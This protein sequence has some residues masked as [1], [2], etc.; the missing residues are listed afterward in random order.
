MR[1]PNRARLT[2]DAAL[3][4]FCSA[5]DY[6]F[7]TNG[8]TPAERSCRSFLPRMSA[9]DL[10][11]QWRQ[12][13]HAPTAGSR[14]PACSDSGRVERR[15]E[16][17]RHHSFGCRAARSAIAGRHASKISSGGRLLLRRLE[18]EV[19]CASSSRFVAVDGRPKRYDVLWT[20]PGTPFCPKAALPWARENRPEIAACS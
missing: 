13:S 18:P 8:I 4:L 15:P 6:W 3:L 5:S 12:R 17:P 7:A 14:G 20:R 1:K 16:H 11:L 2:S 9:R 10:P 19:A